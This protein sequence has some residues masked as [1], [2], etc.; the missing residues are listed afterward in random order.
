MDAP[1]GCKQHGHIWGWHYEG[2]ASTGWAVSFLL[3]MIG[4]RKQLSH[5][6]WHPFWHLRFYS[7][8]L[9]K[10]TDYNEWSHES[11]QDIGTSVKFGA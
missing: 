1:E 3:C 6:V 9:A 5:I 8:L 4:L 7:L 11:G 10:R 2:V